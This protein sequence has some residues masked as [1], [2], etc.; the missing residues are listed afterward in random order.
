ME[1]GGVSQLVIPSDDY[2][3][4]GEMGLSICIFVLP[5]E[6]GDVGYIRGHSPQNRYCAV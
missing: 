3:S 6:R 5:G 4:M 2:H 1:P